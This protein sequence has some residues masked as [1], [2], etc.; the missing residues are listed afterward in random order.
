M[1]AMTSITRKALAGAV[2]AGAIGSSGCYGLQKCVDPCWPERYNYKARTEVIAAFAPQVQNGHILDQTLYNTA[3]V[4]GTDELTNIGRDQIDTLVRRRPAPD[5]RIFLATA[6]D[7]SYDPVNPG[8]YIEGRRTLDNA[9]AASIQR[10]L[11][12][13]TAG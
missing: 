4:A 3:F 6:R 1:R 9:R 5:P 11:A 13:Q 7:L 2:L 8:N 10:Y 12:A